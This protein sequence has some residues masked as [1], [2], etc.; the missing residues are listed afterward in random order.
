MAVCFLDSVTLGK[1]LNLSDPDFLVC[2]MSL[3][4]LSTP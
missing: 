2:N 1:T 3:R 4:I